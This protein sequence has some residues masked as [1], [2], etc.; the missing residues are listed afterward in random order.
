MI[1]WEGRLELGERL[2]WSGRPAPVARPMLHAPMEPGARIVISLLCGGLALL[3]L[4]LF[5]PAARGDPWFMALP[6]AMAGAL[7][8]AI[9]ISMAARSCSTAHCWREPVTP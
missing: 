4:F 2:L 5:L 6:L 7:F 1:D 8:L 3:S 9:C